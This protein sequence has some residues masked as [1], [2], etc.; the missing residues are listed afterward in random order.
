MLG[1]HNATSSNNG[2]T[3]DLMV[4][5]TANVDGVESAFNDTD[6]ITGNATISATEAVVRCVELTV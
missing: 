3:G 5:D 2:D 1:R 4:V 6:V